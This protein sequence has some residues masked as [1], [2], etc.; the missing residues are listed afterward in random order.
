[1]SGLSLSLQIRQWTAVPLLILSTVETRD[2]E[3]RLLDL[4][5]KGYLSEPYDISMVAIRINL[6]LSMKLTP[7]TK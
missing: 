5:S 2:K 1:L 3:I 4:R 7:T 6:I